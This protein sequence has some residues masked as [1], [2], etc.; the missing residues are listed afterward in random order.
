MRNEAAKTTVVKTTKDKAVETNKRRPQKAGEMKKREKSKKQRGFIAW[1][2][3]APYRLNP[4][5]TSAIATSAPVMEN[6]A[7]PPVVLY[8]AERVMFG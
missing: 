1:R 2:G 5:A 3:E 4:D 8:A 6:D 7:P